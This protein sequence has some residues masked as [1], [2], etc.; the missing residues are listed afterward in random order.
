[1]KRRDFVN[2][3]LASAGLIPAMQ[4]MATPLPTPAKPAAGYSL[5]ILATNW[6]YRGTLDEFCAAVKKEGYDGL[7]LWWTDK[8][9]AQK[10]L[11]TAWR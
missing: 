4:A 7:E 11:V 10:E 3:T 8:P 9:D 6:G 1:M 5:K 2:T